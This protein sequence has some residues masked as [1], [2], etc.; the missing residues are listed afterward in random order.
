MISE[1]GVMSN[2]ASRGNPCLLRPTMMERRAR[3]FMSI[4]RFPRDFA[5]VDVQCVEEHGVVNDGADEVVRGGDGVEV[6]RKVH[7]DFLHRRQG[8]LS[9]AG[10]A[11]LAAGKTGPMEGWRS[12]RQAF[13]PMAWSP[14]ARPMDTVV[15]PSPEG[16]G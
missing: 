6:P 5:F 9:A 11:A 15:F 1:A 10:G 12:A 7:V 8:A 4:T 16:V 14:C 13:L 3:S 2:P